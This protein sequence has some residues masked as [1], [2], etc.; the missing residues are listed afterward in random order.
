MKTLPEPA[1]PATT[2]KLN[3]PTSLLFKIAARSHVLAEQFGV[4]LIS[5]D[6]KEHTPLE[7]YNVERPWLVDDHGELTFDADRY[8][9]TIDACSTYTRH[10]RLFILNVWNPGY[11]KS[12]GWT[13]DLFAALRGLD[14]NN[15]RAIAWFCKTSVWP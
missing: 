2:K 5:P 12:K 15:S 14:D 8:A 10:M 9:K 3:S 11:A 6:T 1:T 13:F 4:K 7:F